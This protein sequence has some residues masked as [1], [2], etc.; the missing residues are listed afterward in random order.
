MYG[1]YFCLDDF[2]I[3]L[4]K[5][6]VCKNRAKVDVHDCFFTFPIHV[7]VENRHHKLTEMLIWSNASVNVRVLMKLNKANPKKEKLIPRST[8]PKVAPH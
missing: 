2:W 6:K 1:V 8:T 3:F 4:E 7:A 5:N